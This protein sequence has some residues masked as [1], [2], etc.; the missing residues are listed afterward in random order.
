M[1]YAYPT[2]GLDLPEGLMERCVGLAPRIL[3]EV[4][5]S[6]PS[7]RFLSHIEGRAGIRI[8]NQRVHFDEDLVRTFVDEFIEQ[9]RKKCVPLD[10][11]LQTRPR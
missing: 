7:D 5:M 6:A 2:Y 8:A 1:Q 9:A 11:V 10:E 4:G 3:H